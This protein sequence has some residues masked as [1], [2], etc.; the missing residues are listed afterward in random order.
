MLLTFM[1]GFILFVIPFYIIA[2]IAIIEFV[3]HITKSDSD[4]ER[5]YIIEK[6]KWF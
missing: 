3:M 2:V 6:K 5:I 4:F 1:F